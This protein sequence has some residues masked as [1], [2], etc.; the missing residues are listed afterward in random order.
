MKIKVVTIGLAL[1]LALAP[2]AV[3][4]AQEVLFTIAGAGGDPDATFVLP[5][6]PSPD[7]VAPSVYFGF[8]SVAAT[9][10]G[11][12]SDLFGLDFYNASDEGGLLDQSYYS[13]IGAQLYTGP[14]DSPMFQLGVYSMHNDLT[15]NTDIVTLAAVPETSTWAMILAGFVGL[16]FAGLR[17]NHRSS[18]Y[19]HSAA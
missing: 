17:R 15:G 1:A 18:A 13:L 8:Y 14:E 12:P 11:S 7:F 5:Q 19:D 10:E 4:R 2:P 3:A 6:N 9:I 16:G